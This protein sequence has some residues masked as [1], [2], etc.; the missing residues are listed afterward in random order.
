MSIVII[1]PRDKNSPSRCN[2]F[3]S[4]SLFL[5]L[6][7][8]FF[9]FDTQQ[10]VICRSRNKRVTEKVVK[11][12]F[13]IPSPAS[14]SNVQLSKVFLSSIASRQKDFNERGNST[15][16][17]K[18]TWTFCW[19]KRSNFR[20]IPCSG[21]KKLKQKSIRMDCLY[22]S[23]SWLCVCTWQ[24]RYMMW[25]RS[26]IALEAGLKGKRLVELFWFKLCR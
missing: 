3:L 26:F 6:F 10:R 16:L 22:T 11:K 17:S 19:V 23:T 14:E 8:F 25:G 20:S 13:P 4:L 12:K 5:L 15:E 2:F 1:I 18:T 7:H 9:P 21:R 24:K